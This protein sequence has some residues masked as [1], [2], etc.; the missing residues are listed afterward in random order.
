MEILTKQTVLGRPRV[1]PRFCYLLV[2]KPAPRTTLVNMKDLKDL[3]NSWCM[4]G[5]QDVFPE[6]IANFG[7]SPK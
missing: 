5:L 6:Y 4:I 7:F 1:G 3:P 2:L